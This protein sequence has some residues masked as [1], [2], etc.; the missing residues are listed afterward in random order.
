MAA[1]LAGIVPRLD[2]DPPA[3]DIP[4]QKKGLRIEVDFP[5]SRSSASSELPATLTAPRRDGVYGVDSPDPSETRPEASRGGIRE[6]GRFLALFRSGTL[7]CTGAGACG[8][9]PRTAA[10]E[11]PG[12]GWGSRRRAPSGGT[13]AR[14]VRR[15]H[16]CRGGLTRRAWFFRHPGR[17]AAARGSL[18]PR[19][20]AEDP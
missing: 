12:L 14:S 15:S 17:R 2:N 18:D 5:S 4:L 13:H 8:V 19:G 11:E 1:A 20:P 6:E 10:P 7:K 9:A 3:V 16:P